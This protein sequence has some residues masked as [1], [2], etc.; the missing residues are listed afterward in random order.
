MLRIHIR[1]PVT[2]LLLLAASLHAGADEAREILFRDA[3][4]A[5][6]AA[7]DA[8]GALLA[9]ESFEDAEK[10]FQRAAD[11]YAR[12]RSLERVSR[13]LNDATENYRLATAVATRA[14]TEFD[15]VL[16]ARAAAI[17]AGADT[18]GLDSWADAE[19]R[20]RLAAVSLER[21]DNTLAKERAATA[22]DMYRGTELEAIKKRLLTETRALIEQARR[23]R[24]QRNAPST[25]EKAQRLLAEAE[26]ALEEDRYDTDRPRAL[27][28][29][30]HYEARHAIYLAQYLESQ[31]DRRATE[32]DLILAMEE[33]LRRVA[34]A[35]EIAA[36]F[37]KGPA[38]PAAQV[39]EYLQNQQDRVQ[40]LEQD[41]DERTRQVFALEQEITEVYD[42]LGGVTGQRQAME[43]QL[44]RQEMERQRLRQVEEMFERDEARV[45][46][47]GEDV[48][49]R[50]TGLRFPVGGAEIPAAGQDLMDRV[51]TALRLYPDAQIT[52]TGHTDSFGSDAAN[53]AL[54][55][56]RADSV[57][58]YLLANLR[59]A[60]ARIAAVGYGETQPVSSNETPEGRAN[61]RR[62]DLVV[63]P[64]R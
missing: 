5:R 17:E 16:D 42:R 50:L 9:P 36:E 60:P 58:A 27:A 34:A 37:D 22:L 26:T 10:D 24:V 61:N 43:R 4:A 18:L 11:A 23:N 40:N 3:E 63:R 28:R 48:I 62:I 31:R 54:S 64:A 53:F 55:R 7:I 29:E 30:A 56:K 1:L 39:V 57:R 14:Q 13:A 15:E 33:P 52:V 20:F 25:L 49:L 38:E 19:R 45:L 6:A 8:R 35:A 21:A 41:L 12:G 59:I 46:R 44:E 47:Q 2:A 51:Q 32:E